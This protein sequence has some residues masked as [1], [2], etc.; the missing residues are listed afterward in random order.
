[1]FETLPN[2]TT[3]KIDSLLPWSQSIPD[4]CRMPDKKENI[5]DDEAA[6]D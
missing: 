2:T 6:R 5:K 3:G 4:R 1:L